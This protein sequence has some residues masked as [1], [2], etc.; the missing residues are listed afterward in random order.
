MNFFINH[1]FPDKLGYNIYKFFL[2]NKHFYQINNLKQ[3]GDLIIYNGYFPYDAL[4]HYCRIKNLNEI[5]FIKNEVYKIYHLNKRYLKNT[6]RIYFFYPYSYYDR[7]EYPN[8]FIKE[9]KIQLSS[10]FNKQVFFILNNFNDNENINFNGFGFDC[11]NLSYYFLKNNDYHLNKEKIFICLN[12][13]TRDHRDHLH[14]FLI[15]NDLLRYFYFSYLQKKINFHEYGDFNKFYFSY[16]K[17]NNIH[18]SSHNLYKNILNDDLYTINFRDFFKKSFYYLITETTHSENIMFISE[19]T[20]KAFFH[21]I[22]FIIIGNPGSLKF[23]HQQGF[24][25]FSPYIDESYDLELNYHERKQ[26][27]YNEIIRLC[28]LSIKDHIEI[29]NSLQEIVQYNWNHYYLNYNN[30]FKKHFFDLFKI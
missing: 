26:K 20:Y 21:K 22:P 6:N 9:L 5:V 13:K 30:R 25:T 17:D 19:K 23:L 12:N 8:D 14:N 11:Y 1:F 7:L 10:I 27:I 3:K 29:N 28:N 18:F 24:K 4:F 16:F 2:F 15:N